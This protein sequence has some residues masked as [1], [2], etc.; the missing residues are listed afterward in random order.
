MELFDKKFV[1][2]MWDDKLV[3]KQVFVSDYISDL[4]RKID[5]GIGD[6][7]RIEVK[8]SDEEYHPFLVSSGDAFTFVYYDPLYDYKVAYSRGASI[9]YRRK[10]STTKWLPIISTSSIWNDECYEYRIKPKETVAT[11]RE[12]LEWL[13]KGNG[14]VKIY[15]NAVSISFCVS[16]ADMDESCLMDEPC[17]YK[18]CKWEDREWHDATHEY[19]GIGEN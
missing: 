11:N 6:Y 2:F 10:D 8:K 13:A 4:K 9:E 17:P 14:M 12:V 19:L 7:A 1:Y 5:I 18:V 3:G 16:E 15:K